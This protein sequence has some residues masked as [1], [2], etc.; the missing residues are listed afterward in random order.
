[1]KCVSGRHKLVLSARALSVLGSRY[2]FL[3][4]PAGEGV[5]FSSD[6]SVPDAPWCPGFNDAIDSRT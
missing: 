6:L 5:G 4:R 3:I 2:R 1:M